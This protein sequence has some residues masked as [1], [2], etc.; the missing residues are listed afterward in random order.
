ME[1]L[2]NNNGIEYNCAQKTGTILYIED[3]LSNIELVEEILG[4]H[5][6]G[7]R[8]IKSMLGKQAV[9]LAMDYAP[10]LILLDLDL[11]DIHGSIVFENLQNEIKTK[12]MPVV[13]V[14][15]DAMTQ[16][17]DKMLKAGVKGYI[18]KPIDIVEF[19]K[20]VDAWI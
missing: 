2:S 20:T 11:P 14:S 5:R 17:I 18:T 9:N 13:V 10:N 4:N 8:I 12:D 6:P 1:E 15:A 16:Q 7:I 19:I 3:K